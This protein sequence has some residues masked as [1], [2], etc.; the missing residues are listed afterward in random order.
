MED[1]WVPDNLSKLRKL[2][3]NKKPCMFGLPLFHLYY[4]TPK[5]DNRMTAENKWKHAFRIIVG[6]TWN[7]AVCDLAQV[8][9]LNEDV[10]KRLTSS[11][12][13][14][15]LQFT[16]KKKGLVNLAWWSLL[17]VEK[18]DPKYV[19][20]MTLHEKIKDLH[21]CMIE[22]PHWMTAMMRYFSD[23]LAKYA[24]DAMVA[25][26]YIPFKV[27]KEYFD[28]YGNNAFKAFQQDNQTDIDVKYDITMDILNWGAR[29]KEED[30]RNSM[31]SPK[32]KQRLLTK[33]GINSKAKHRRKNGNTRSV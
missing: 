20:I 18:D 27:Q 30:I 25:L 22:Y 7:W 10:D 3:D 17:E 4:T 23:N 5:D 13:S 6:L 28:T 32:Q 15:L 26:I 19:A 24:D 14:Q 11:I 31:I 21:D 29:Q 16:K 9:M 12:T 33:C 1:Y 2:V 8:Y